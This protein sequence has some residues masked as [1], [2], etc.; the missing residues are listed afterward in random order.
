MN[1]LKRTKTVHVLLI[2]FS[3]NIIGFILDLFIDDN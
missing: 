2:D 1:V 3:G